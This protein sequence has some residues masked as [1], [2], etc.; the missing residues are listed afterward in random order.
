CQGALQTGAPAR[1]RQRGAQNARRLT[2]AAVLASSRWSRYDGS[3]ARAR[4]SAEEHYLDMVGVT[5]SIPVAPTIASIP[6][7]VLRGRSGPGPSISSARAPSRGSSGVV[8]Q[9]Q[10]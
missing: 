10:M 1:A 7:D 9:G 5:G 8:H 4:S 3:G 6:V 2:R